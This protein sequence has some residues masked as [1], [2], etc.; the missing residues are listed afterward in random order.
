VASLP[1]FNAYNGASVWIGGKKLQ[2]ESEYKWAKK[3]CTNQD[4]D[5]GIQM[6][7]DYTLCYALGQSVASK[8]Y[9]D[10]VFHARDCNDYQAF[11]CQVKTHALKAAKAAEDKQI[12]LKLI[13]HLST[14]CSVMDCISNT[15]CY[16]DL[17][18]RGSRTWKEA[19]TMCGLE[20]M[21]MVI[22]NDKDELTFLTTHEELGIRGYVGAHDFSD[23][24]KLTWLDEGDGYQSTV[25]DSDLIS[26]WT[27]TTGGCLYLKRSDPP[28][29]LQNCEIPGEIFCEFDVNEYNEKWTQ[30]QKDY[31]DLEED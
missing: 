18:Q 11:A 14:V 4:L 13:Q 26:N 3:D 29:I 30:K 7:P 9:W 22:I 27:A 19:V 21:N 10:D 25:P 17:A 28:F 12:S 15:H 1:L 5:F 23:E 8:Y 16:C 31:E 2:D 6:N 24:K 20:D